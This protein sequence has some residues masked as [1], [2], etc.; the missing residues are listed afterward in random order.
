M[1]EKYDVKIGS[2]KYN[3]QLFWTNFIINWK[4]VVE[5]KPNFYSVLIFN[6]VYICIYVLFAIVLNNLILEELSWGIKEFI[7]FIFLTEIFV[8]TVGIFHFGRGLVTMHKNG[9]LNSYL[10]KPTNVLLSAFSIQRFNPTLFILTNLMIYLP[11]IIY[12]FD[13]QFVNIVYGVLLFIML[14]IIQTLVVHFIMSL[15]FIAYELEEIAG[16]MYWEAGYGILA[17]YPAQFFQNRINVLMV[18]SIFPVYFI[19]MWIVPLLSFGS[20]EVRQFEIIILSV[21]TLISLLGIVVNW[22]YGLKRYEAF[23]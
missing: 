13:F 6:S 17:R 18:V 3:L 20:F 4:G 8:D 10:T 7:L 14:I 2:L 16:R 21:V 22:K 1:I 12:L 9:T 15:G 11:I 23:S 19:S 5:Y